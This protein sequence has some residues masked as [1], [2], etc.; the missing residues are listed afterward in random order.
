[1]ALHDYLVIAFA[2]LFTAAAMRI[3]GGLPSVLTSSNRYWVHSVFTALMP[4][5]LAVG[6]W[7]EWALRDVGWTLPLFL[8]A[9]LGP[10]IKY[11][12]SCTLV[13]ENP[14]EVQS[15][16]EYYFNIRTRFFGGLTFLLIVQ[17]V[18][19]YVFFGIPW[20]DP[21]RI[22]DALFLGLAITGWVSKSPRVHGTLAVIQAGLI[23]LMIAT[24]ASQPGWL[25][26]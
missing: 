8:L 2:L 5:A 16:R 22:A 26:E 12:M 18:G 17:P 7:N 3:I 10:S 21:L 19:A 6:F 4:L 15:W 11:F 24:F 23:I 25:A 20:N 13:P 1:M 14:A 9:L